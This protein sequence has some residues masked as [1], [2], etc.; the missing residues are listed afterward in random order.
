MTVIAA[1]F[2]D[3]LT[4][5]RA[6][7]IGWSVLGFSATVLFFLRFFIQWLKSEK[8]KRVVM[9]VSFWRFSL[10]GALLNLP[11]CIHL[12]KEP[13]IVGAFV[14]LI[15]AMGNLNLAHHDGAPRSAL[16]RSLPWSVPVIYAGFVTHHLWH[17]AIGWETVGYIGEVLFS[18]RFVMQWIASERKGII[19][20]PG[21]FWYL[22]LLGGCVRLTYAGYLW[23]M[24]I[25]IPT[26]VSVL[27]SAR[28][29]WL[30]HRGKTP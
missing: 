8:A 27:M 22:S 6:E 11:Y 23:K 9:P 30:H 2:Q 28:N 13:L 17:D 20:V 19:V 25:F 10:A 14:S 3:F 18:S 12:W 29:A 7:H 24:P 26:I 4:W 16:R 5:L 1:S 15:V 21:Y